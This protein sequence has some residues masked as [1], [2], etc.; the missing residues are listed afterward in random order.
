MKADRTSVEAVVNKNKF[1]V[2]SK[3]SCPYAGQT[4]ALLSKLSVLDQGKVV[5]LDQEQNGVHI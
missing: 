5:E 1:V 4:K 2:F 3:T